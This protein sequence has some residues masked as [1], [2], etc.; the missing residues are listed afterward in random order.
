MRLGAE[1]E[2]WLEELP[3]LVGEFERR[4]AIRVGHAFDPGGVVGFVAPATMADGTP[5]VFKIVSSIARLRTRRWYFA[6]M[7]GVERCAC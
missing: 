4:W 5:A 6:S 1:G 3:R 7:M 2:A